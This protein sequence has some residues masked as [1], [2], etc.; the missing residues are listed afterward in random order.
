MFVAPQDI[1]G[2]VDVAG[3]H[4]VDPLWDADGPHRRGACRACGTS[5]VADG[6]GAQRHGGWRFCAPGNMIKS[7]WI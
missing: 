5:K 6:R 2:D 3:S 7:Q 1:V 4:V